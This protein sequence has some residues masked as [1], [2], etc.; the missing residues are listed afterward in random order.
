MAPS[1]HGTTLYSF[2]S[3]VINHFQKRQ[4]S[5]HVWVI[6]SCYR[7]KNSYRVSLGCVT[8]SLVCG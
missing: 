6:W 1:Q 8:T 2:G 5:I 4:T 3:F 7:D